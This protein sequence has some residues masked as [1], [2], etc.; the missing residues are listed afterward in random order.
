VTKPK[1]FDYTGNEIAVIGMSGRFP[2]AR[3]LEEF[4]DVLANGRETIS[5]FTDEEMRAA[6]VSEAL[7]NHP[8]YVKAK[9]AL[10]DVEHFDADFFGYTPKEAAMMDPQFRLLHE[11]VWEALEDAG[12]DPQT[13]K[14][15]IGLYAGAAFNSQWTMRALQMS[16]SGDSDTLE[17]AVLNLRDYFSTLVSYN[18]NL[19]GPSFTLQT[20][21]S[22]S[23]VAIH[24]AS[25]ALLSGECH[26]ALAGGVS[27]NLPQKSGYLYQDGMINSPDGHCR[28]FDERA[29]GTIFGDGAGIVALKMLE[30][31][32]E[33]G[34]PIYA[35]IKGSAINNDGNRKVG[36]TAP[37]TKGQAAVIRSALSVAEVEADTISYIEAH[38][39][40]T[41][42]GDPIE[43]EALKAAFQTDAIGTC[44]IGSVKSNF[45]HLNNAAGVSGFIKT[46]LALKHK[47]IPPT[48]HY[49]RPNPKIDFANSPFVVNTELTP[50]EVADGPLRAG[51]SSFGIGGTN[52]HI[53]LE[54]AP[55]REQAASER[56]HHLLVLS[57][58]SEQALEQST[59]NLLRHLEAHPDLSL[60]DTA[61]TLQTGRR[62]FPHRRTLVCT[63]TADAIAA[64]RE[65]A[66]DRFDN[67]R[68]DDDNRPVSFLFSGQGAQYVEMAR[69]L[70][71][72]EPLFQQEIDRCLDL[73]KPH[74]HVNLADILY[75]SAA[76]KDRAADSINH[77]AVAQPLLF[78]VEYALARQ[79]MAWGIQPESMIGHSIGEYVAACLAGVMTLADA[80]RLV[81]RRG[82]LMQEMPTGSMLSV[83]LPADRLTAE[84][85]TADT[86]DLSLAAN[87]APNLC[88]VSGTT[89]AITAL[90]ARLSAQ[91]IENRLLHTSH[92]FHSFM[93]EPMLAA[94]EA[95]VAKTPL[96]APTIPYVSNVTG[97]W[98]TDAEATSP[99]YWAQHLRGTVQFAAGVHTLLEDPRRVFVEVGPGRTL[100]TFVRDTTTRGTATTAVPMIRHPREEKADHDVLLRQLGRL[101][102]AGVTVKWEAL[103]TDETRTRLSLPTY[104]FERKRYWLEESGQPLAAG[105]RVT[106][107]TG[108]GDTNSASTADRS[109]S[110]TYV[111]PSTETERTLAAIWSDLFGLEQIG[112]QDDFF[113]IGGHSLKATTLI[114]RIHKELGVELSLPDIFKHSTIRQL[115]RLIEA[116]ERTQYAPITPVAKADWYPLSSSQ[117]RNYLIH[118]KIGRA[119]TYNMPMALIAR[120]EPD[121]PRFEASM[122]QMIDRHETLRTSFHFL[123]GEPVQIVHDEYEFA[124]EYMEATEDQLDGIVRSFI[125]P[126]DLEQAPLL[127]VLFVRLEPQK[128]ALLVDMHNI[129]SD[130]S[131][132]NVFIQE[133]TN[134]YRGLEL[135]PVRVQYKDYAHWQSQLLESEQLQRQEDYWREQ[136]FSQPITRLRM[137]LDFPRGDTQTYVGQAIKFSVS[138][139][140]TDKVTALAR[141]H[142]LTINA[143]LLNVYALALAYYSDLDEVMM[144]TLVAGRNHADAEPLIGLFTNF[145]PLRFQLTKDSTFLDFVHAH[146]EQIVGAYANQDYP[147]D[148]MVERLLDKVPQNRNPLFDTML[149]YHNEYD[150]DVVLDVDGLTFEVYEFKKGISKLDFKVDVVSEVTDELKFVLQYNIGLFKQ[151]TMLGFSRHLTHLLE[152]LVTHPETRIGDIDLFTAE[153]KQII[154]AKRA[155]NNPPLAPEPLAL[156]V[157]ATFTAEPLAAAL[158]GLGDTQLGGVDVRFAPYNQ[159][160]QQLYDK[161]SLFARNRGANL[162]LVR[163]EDWL[164]DLHLPE[165]EQFRTL[166]RNFA[167]LTAALHQRPGTAPFFVGLFPTSP[168]LAV[169]ETARQYLNVMT[170]R[171]RQALE[172]L[173]GVYP[174][175]LTHLADLYQIAEPYDLAT[176]REAHMP[177]TDAYYAA[178]GAACIRAVAAWKRTPY[179]V[180]ALDCDNVLWSGIVGEQ[181]VDGLTIDPARQ[182]L[183]DWLIRKQQEGFLLA[184]C[185]KNEAADVWAVFDQHADMRL[186]REHIAAWQIGW[187]R[188]S[189]S[190]RALADELNVGLDSFL[191]LDDSAAE[192]AEVMATCPEVLTLHVPEHAEHLLAFVQH[193]WAFDRLHVTTEDR[194][195]TASYQAERERRTLRD[196]TPSLSDFQQSLELAVSVRPAELA[197]VTRLAQLTERTTQ[198]T[199]TGQ[200][201]DGSEIGALLQAD[202]HVVYAI[203]AADRFGTYGVIGAVI[204][205]LRQQTLTLDTLL[206]S[207][208]ALGRG[209]EEAL[210]VALSRLGRANGWTHIEAT[211]RPQPRNRQ[212]FD[213]L[214]ASGFEQTAT[215]STHTTFTIAIA[216]L[217][218]EAPSIQLLL[219]EPLPM[220]PAAQEAA[221]TYEISAT[222]EPQTV[223]PTWQVLTLDTENLTHRNDL[224]PLQY[225][226]GEQLLHLLSRHKEHTHVSTAPYSAP[227]NE[228]QTQLVTIWQSVLGT[229]QI[230]IDDDFFQLG[231]SSLLAIKLKV[232]MEKQGLALTDMNLF[233]NRT[234]RKLAQLFEPI[235]EGVR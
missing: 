89:E 25:Q 52:A 160:F 18:L 41:M 108:A 133:F 213:W 112:V 206:L 176:D 62:A 210:L 232:E 126:F 45:G 19:K 148:R 156:A 51:V 224:L 137:P 40:G 87:N 231:G 172:E 185:S 195:R 50:W 84:L 110:S 136:I 227:E 75:P 194:T 146:N 90:S 99:S 38:G 48:L 169:S 66:S 154:S 57:A 130:G 97:T 20:G 92:A 196:T 119:T 192:C 113:E 1:E 162:L 71:R 14:G 225:H 65:R 34:D 95:E 5:F 163:F 212:V 207:C 15:M 145:L 36:Y 187:A 4:W 217:P 103:H 141:T 98:I 191:F 143:L 124:I 142:N 134:L 131:S 132:M 122:R 139:D 186:R 31:A 234:I 86:N 153:D 100:C 16:Q 161:N 214:A 219:G 166:E 29:Q 125:R 193:V 180:I 67:G 35:V 181:G 189:D 121:I 72:D 147:F 10:D 74:V 158:V 80:L 144:G 11:C 175:D 165:A 115:T 118:Q 24:L 85:A 70:Y 8:S 128:H 138:K 216:A 9:G 37:S 177:F 168:Q 42:L 69:G 54:E 28:V 229:D 127:R 149:I 223:H 46:V 174:V 77:T 61:Y 179:K 167:E 164:R 226:T 114:S 30:D 93:M 202:S 215:S 101:W 68:S 27:I 211:Y 140:V 198:F 197:D 12:Y 53:V 107:V 43:I 104:P 135:P 183:H 63:D 199:L 21:C 13:Y 116:A 91:G 17:A 228:L 155:A 64:L 6:G 120:G 32:L 73:I 58:R 7:L 117:K 171:F 218:A 220:A 182:R 209:V 49:E 230:G 23:L 105:G 47:Q 123:D 235:E 159:P 96:S 184:L 203:E 79:L 2:G 78:I 157:S 208:R 94:F 56:P 151:E 205:S 233:A 39:T 3:N 22:T 82:Q 76:N 55:E 83:S 44:R 222:V 60:A 173:D 88:V 200:R 59:A 109:A 152:L 204:G 129:I 102:M 178:I 26:I 190:L 188:K 106:L 33:D 150:P 81:A 221:A 170:I 111:A 201:R